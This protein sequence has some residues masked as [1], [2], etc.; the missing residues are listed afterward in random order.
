MGGGLDKNTD[1]ISCNPLEYSAACLYA[2][3]LPLIAIGAHAQSKN[4][5]NGLSVIDS[6]SYIL[7]M[8]LIA[9]AV[10]VAYSINAI[11]CVRCYA[12]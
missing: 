4:Q 10:L 3:G 8:L 6:V 12:Q 7:V 11:S 9:G 2:S 5:P 1:L